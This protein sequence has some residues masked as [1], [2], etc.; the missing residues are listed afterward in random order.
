MGRRKRYTAEQK[1]GFD[2]PQAVH[3]QWHIDFSY[4]RICGVFYSFVSILDNY[5]RNILAWDL[6]ENMEGIQAE[7]LVIRQM[8]YHVFL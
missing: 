8:V 6:C 5:S 7:N 4:L 3:E 1:I 2:Q